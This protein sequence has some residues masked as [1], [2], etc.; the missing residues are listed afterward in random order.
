MQYNQAF[1]NPTV[2]TINPVNFPI[3][4]QT[5]K[6]ALN[7]INFPNWVE[8]IAYFERLKNQPNM[9]VAWVGGDIFSENLSDQ[10][11]SSDLTAYLRRLMSNPNI[12]APTNI[13]RSR[14]GSSPYFRGSY[15]FM[16]VGSSPDDFARLTN[17]ILLNNVIKVVFLFTLLCNNQLTVSF[18]LF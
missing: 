1:W 13:V 2:D 15:T 8:H 12:P 18:Y 6:S 4:G 16:P 9:L 3:N 17:P 10:Q 14:W 7:D 11:I 5:V